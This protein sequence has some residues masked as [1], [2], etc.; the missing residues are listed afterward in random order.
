DCARLLEEL[1]FSE[2]V[3]TLADAMKALRPLVADVRVVYSPRSLPQRAGARDRGRIEHDRLQATAVGR[4]PLRRRL[5]KHMAIAVGR[6]P[7]RAARAPGSHA[8]ARAN[9]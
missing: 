9:Q 8:F 6:K 2:N 4:S 1:L 5:P 7:A 3:P